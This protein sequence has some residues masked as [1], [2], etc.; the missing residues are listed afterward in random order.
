MWLTIPILRALWQNSTEVVVRKS[1]HRFLS[2]PQAIAPLAR[3]HWEFAWLS[4][5]AYQETAA[6]HKHVN[7]MRA[8]P[9]PQIG[10]VPPDPFAHLTAAGW[11]LWNNFPGN[12]LLKQIKDS[13]LRVQVWERDEPPAVAV[14]FGGTVFNNDADWG[15]QS[16][17]VLSWE[18][19]RI[20]G[21]CA[22]VCTHL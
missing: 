21:C 14:T 17:M 4:D 9:A 6:G 18:T 16:S 8:K 15:G 11:K 3:E 2:A 1:G 5:A 10:E 20:H 19:R 7:K 22:D 12:G 13:H